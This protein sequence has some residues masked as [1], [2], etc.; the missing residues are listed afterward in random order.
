MKK[1]V[2]FGLTALTLA[3]QSTGAMASDTLNCSSGANGVDVGPAAR[4]NAE[5]KLNVAVLTDLPNGQALLCVN[6]RNASRSTMIGAIG[7]LVGDTKLVGMDY[8]VQDGKLYAVGNMGGVYT[9]DTINATANLVNRLTVALEG[10]LFGV[11]FNPAA[12]R[13]RIVSN[14]GQNLRHNVNMG[15]T[16]IADSTLNNVG[17]VPQPVNPLTGIVSGAYTNNDLQSA[18]GTTLLVISGSSNTVALQSPANSGIIATTG[19]LGVKTSGPVGFDIYNTLRNG[20]ATSNRALASATVEGS[21]SAVLFS[22]DLL[23][24]AA[25]KASSFAKG[26]NVVDIAIPLN[27]KTED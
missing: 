18:T 12:D 22:V 16:T 25:T 21:S 13:L 10:T 23:T 6:E 17:A 8:R 15:G 5:Q 7:A 1:S 20:V 19:S 2:V 3:L 27:Q 11:D 24:G 26:V 14:T 9:I 4:S